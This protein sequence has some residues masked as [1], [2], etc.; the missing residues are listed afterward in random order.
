MSIFL[1]FFFLVF[2][3]ADLPNRNATRCMQGRTQA[4]NFFGLQRLSNTSLRHDLILV[5]APG[6]GQRGRAEWGELFDHYIRTRD[7]YVTHSNL[8]DSHNFTLCLTPQTTLY[9]H[10]NQRPT[11]GNRTR[12]TDAPLSPFRISRPAIQNSTHHHQNGQNASP[13]TNANMSSSTKYSSGSKS[14]L[15]SSNICCWRIER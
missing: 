14:E 7:T 2:S 4:L 5:D 13:K 10:P 3:L 6:Y 15:A 11:R 1:A 12:Q 8:E 9:I